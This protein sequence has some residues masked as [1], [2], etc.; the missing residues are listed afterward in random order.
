MCYRK[1]LIAAKKAVLMADQLI[2]V[3]LVWLHTQRAHNQWPKR[4]LGKGDI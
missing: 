1:I 3:C 2:A 4:S